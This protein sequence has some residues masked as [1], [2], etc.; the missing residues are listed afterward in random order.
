MKFREVIAIGLAAA[1]LSLQAVRAAEIEGV[2][3][4]EQLSVSD[5]ELRLHGT[6]L[7]RYRVFIKGY[8][9]ALYLAESFGGQSTP[10]T[11]LGDRALDESLRRQLLASR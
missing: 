11:V 10:S 1:S 6:E 2:Q 8:F 3:F 5:E 7:L 9:A 4:V